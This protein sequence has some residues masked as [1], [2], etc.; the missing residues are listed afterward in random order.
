MGVAV[1]DLRN[2]IRAARRGGRR[3]VLAGHSLGA[4]IAIA[5]ATWDFGERAGAEDLAGLVLIDGG[6]GRAPIRRPAAREQLEQLAAGSPFLDLS[7][8][9]LPWAIGGLAAGAQVGREAALGVGDLRLPRGERVGETHAAQ[10]Q[11]ALGGAV[12]RRALRRLG[13][14]ARLGSRVE[15]G[16]ARRRRQ[17]PD[18][19]RR[20]PRQSI[21]AL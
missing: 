8:F 19:R 16:G 14:V 5:Y 9:G 12:D 15:R 2:V 10:Q 7:G 18:H 20:Q 4:T 17:A 6:S 3:V 13:E 21:E 11:L 1:R